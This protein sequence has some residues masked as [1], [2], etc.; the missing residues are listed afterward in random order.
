MTS[1]VVSVLLVV[2]KLAISRIQEA[3]AK[4]RAD[5]DNVNK[6]WDRR[7]PT[8]P[9]QKEANSLRA[10]CLGNKQAFDE[11]FRKLVDRGTNLIGMLRANPR[12]EHNQKL[13]EAFEDLKKDLDKAL[14]ELKNCLKCDQP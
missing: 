4:A 6:C 9:S 13:A 1:A 2:A 11:A 10:P 12:N 3:I 7:G 8:A 14:R 5:R